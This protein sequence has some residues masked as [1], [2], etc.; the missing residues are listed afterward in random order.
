MCSNEDSEQSKINHK[1]FL[2]YIKKEKHPGRN[3]VKDTRLKTERIGWWWW[4]D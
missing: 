2:K 3:G 4:G 1:N